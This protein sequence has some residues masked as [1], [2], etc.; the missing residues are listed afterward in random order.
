MD[1]HFEVVERKKMRKI[2]LG[3]MFIFITLTSAQAY[4]IGGAYEY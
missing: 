1:Y 4:M 2:F 3:I